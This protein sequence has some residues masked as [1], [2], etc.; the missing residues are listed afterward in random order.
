MV[1]RPGRRPRLARPRNDPAQYDDL[2]DSW[3]DPRGPFALLHW[4]AA[5]RVAL[6]P[7][8]AR[9][10]ALLLDLGCGGGLLAPHLAGRGY[11]H[12]GVDLSEPSLRRARAHGVSTVLADVLSLPFPDAC[13]DVVVAGEIFEHVTDLR[14]AVHEACRV[15]ASGGTLVVDTVADTPLA[16]FVTIT[17]GEHVPGGPPPGLHDPR[18]LVDR[19][20]LVQEC[21]RHG[22][23]LR[24]RG[25]RPSVRA[26][27]AWLARRSEYGG[28]TPIRSTAVLFQAVGTKNGMGEG[29]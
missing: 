19:D 16:R 29:R 8:A 17:L 7:P 21:L 4:L 28:L 25:L 20:V 23:R 11:R 22:V 6:V 5:E 24:L 10:G 3:W 13:A 9:D 12:V 27:L 2:A 26:G 1:T 14:R 18:L 15:L